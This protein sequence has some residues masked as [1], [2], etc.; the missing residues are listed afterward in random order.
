MIVSGN[1]SKAG[2]CFW[3]ALKGRKIN[4]TFFPGDRQEGQSIVQPR[5][6]GP[7]KPIRG[8]CMLRPFPETLLPKFEGEITQFV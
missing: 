7:S 6:S 1:A 4:D 8:V 2:N 3:V 5:G